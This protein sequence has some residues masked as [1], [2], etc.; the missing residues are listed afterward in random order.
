[1]ISMPGFYIIVS[2]IGSTVLDPQEQV[3]KSRIG[4][5]NADLEIER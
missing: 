4:D 1:M 3:L 5:A 2:S